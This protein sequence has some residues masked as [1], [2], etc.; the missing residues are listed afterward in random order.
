MHYAS[1]IIS[2]EPLTKP[3]TDEGATDGEK[4]FVNFMTLFEPD[5]ESAKLMKPRDGSF[6]HPARAAQAAA[7]RLA[8]LGDQRFDLP[9]AQRLPMRLR[10]VSAIR[11]NNFG[12]GFGMAGFSCDRRNRIDQ[13]NQFGDI[14]RVGPGQPDHQRNALRVCQNVVLAAQL[15]A[16][17]G[18]G[19]RFFPPH[20]ARTDPESATARDQSSWSA[21][22]NS[23]SSNSWSFCQTPAACHSAKRRQHVM[24]EPQPISWG[25][26]SQG[27]PVLSTN[28]IPVS[29]ARSQ[30]RGRPPSALSG[31]A[32]RR[33]STFNHNSSLTSS[34]AMSTS[35][36]MLV[37]S[38]PLI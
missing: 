28:K 12:F 1:C 5:A 4:G 20:R 7:V 21:A 29:A 22:R 27:I 30:T 31:C 32:G 19:T 2:L 3:Q 34:F 8:A 9:V 14:V 38:S 26:I 16:I 10:I 24:P 33:G 36:G 15:R 23:D 37:V 6:H 17:R 35:G 11:L 13:R 25:S 18:I